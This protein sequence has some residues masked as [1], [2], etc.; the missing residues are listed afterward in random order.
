LNRT[1]P[2]SPLAQLA[3]VLMMSN[4]FQFYD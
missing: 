4:E 3:Q 2:Q 1:K